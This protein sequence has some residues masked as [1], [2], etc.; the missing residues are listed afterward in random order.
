[1]CAAASDRRT[2]VLCSSVHH[3]LIASL[4]SVSDAPGCDHEI[5]RLRRENA[6][7][8]ARVT[9]TQRCLTSVVGTT[10]WR[11]TS[12]SSC[13]QP[14]EGS[15]D[16]WVALEAAFAKEGNKDQLSAVGAKILSWRSCR[17]QGKALSDV[18]L[19][20]DT[21]SL[22]KLRRDRTERTFYSSERIA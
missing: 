1:M 9:G 22:G 21:T 8:L 2:L 15:A 10:S 4:A 12:S 7:K 13:V 11:E 14:V 17:P 16:V 18:S 3:A 5:I 19:W 20:E 6:M